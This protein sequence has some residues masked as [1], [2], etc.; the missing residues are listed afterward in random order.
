MGFFGLYEFSAAPDI[1]LPLATLTRMCVLGRAMRLI[2]V[3]NQSSIPKAFQ[4]FD[5]AGRT[6]PL[7]LYDRVADVREVLMKVTLLTRDRAD[8]LAD[9]CSECSETATARMKRVNLSASAGRSHTL[10]LP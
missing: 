9:R 3:P 2:T 4:E 8:Y 6:D 7:P 5:E 10:S 1:M